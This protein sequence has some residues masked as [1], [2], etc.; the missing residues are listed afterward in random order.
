MLKMRMTLCPVAP[1]Y[2][3]CLIIKCNIITLLF[4]V[5]FDAH[6]DRHAHFVVPTSAAKQ[7]TQ[8]KNKTKNQMEKEVAKQ[9]IMTY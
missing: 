1:A 9:T 5:N 3:L 8:N 2:R 4:F 7:E 6:T